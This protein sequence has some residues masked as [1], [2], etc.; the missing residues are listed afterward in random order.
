MAELPLMERKAVLSKSITESQELS[1]SHYIEQHG[2]ALFGMASLILHSMTLKIA[3]K[4]SL[5]RHLESAGLSLWSVQ[6]DICPLTRAD[7]DRQYVKVFVRASLRWNVLTE[8][9]KGPSPS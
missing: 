8:T 3:L 4:S 7:T 2:K 6:F 9:F 5:M 1:V